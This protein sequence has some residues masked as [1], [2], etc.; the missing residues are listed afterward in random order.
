MGEQEIV[1]CSTANNACAGGW[2]WKAMQ[3]WKDEGLAAEIDYPYTGKKRT[4]KAN[5]TKKL[6]IQVGDITRLNG[7]SEQNLVDHV[8]SLGPMAVSVFSNLK[9]FQLYKSG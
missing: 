2:S 5:E 6:P 7:R 9:T 3:Y 1:D 4:C 8:A